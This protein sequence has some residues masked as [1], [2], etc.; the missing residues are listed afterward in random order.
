MPTHTTAVPHKLLPSLHPPP[1]PKSP[2]QISSLREK[3]S[4]DLAYTVSTVWVYTHPLIYISTQDGHHDQDIAYRKSPFVLVTLSSEECKHW[5]YQ[6]GV[7]ETVQIALIIIQTTAY[8]LS[9]NTDVPWSLPS[10]LK[11]Q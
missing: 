9:L 4:G 3:E 5:S 2:V 1:P 8:Q 7:G 11:Y 6:R 10:H